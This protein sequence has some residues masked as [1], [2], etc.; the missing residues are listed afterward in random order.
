MNNRSQY[1]L[2]S[3]ST[4]SRVIASME[5]R[6]MERYRIVYGPRQSTNGQQSNK[7]SSSTPSNDDAILT[8]DYLESISD[9]KLDTGEEFG[10]K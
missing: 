5:Y 10:Y 4:C 1:F 8:K 6:G 3:N 9:G 2:N 7:S